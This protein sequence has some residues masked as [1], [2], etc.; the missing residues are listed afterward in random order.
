MAGFLD[1]V[2]LPFRAVSRV[3]I[4]ALEWT[5]ARL[6][7][8]QNSTKSNFRGITID[9]TQIIPRIPDVY[10]GLL[11]DTDPV[12]EEAGAAGYDLIYGDHEIVRAMDDLCLTVAAS[13]FTFYSEDKESQKLIPALSRIALNPPKWSALVSDLPH[14]LIQGVRIFSMVFEPVW[15][16]SANRWEMRPKDFI[17][18]NKARFAP[19]RPDWTRMALI[20]EGTLL[21]MNQIGVRAGF[22]R[23]I[24]RDHMIVGVWRDR[25]DRLGWGAGLGP[26]LY[27]L[28]YIRDRLIHVL[29]RAV[30]MH[31]GGVRYALLSENQQTYQGQSAS[32]DAAAKNSVLDA[33]RYMNSF[34][35]SVFPAFVKDVRVAFPTPGSIEAVQNAI[36]GYFEHAVAK[37][38]T[39]TTMI[40]G[41]QSGTAGGARVLSETE[42]IRKQYV[43]N[44]VTEVLQR[45]YVQRVAD[46][47]PWIYKEAGVGFDTP[48]PRLVGTVPGGHNRL[49]EA[50]II[51]QMKVPV[52]LTDIYR[53]TG[54]RQ[55]TEE[56]IKS[57]EVY[58]PSAMD[59][60]KLQSEPSGTKGDLNDPGKQA[61]SKHADRNKDGNALKAKAQSDATPPV[62]A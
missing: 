54:F 60:M 24:P 30:E 35:A 52:L 22:A 2:R 12:L 37:L 33:L 20:D 47:N 44:W 13:D 51:A 62:T 5:T 42:R 39:G 9:H 49:E 29:C 40:S 10:T 38:I 27:K 32:D 56:Q 41:G 19:L 26:I 31:G 15:V 28:A 11:N 45:D 23:E 61:N 55:P 50:Q 53:R 34:D 18:K 7:N 46:F 1:F 48:L 6:R 14:A 4:D 17:V 3:A 25:E 8:L 21:E 43:V 16:A 57:K 36:T 58:D 59:L